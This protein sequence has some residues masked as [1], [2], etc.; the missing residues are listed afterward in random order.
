[1]GGGTAINKII[2]NYSYTGG[3]S[4]HV[5]TTPVIDALLIIDS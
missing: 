5:V 2:T 3:I 1:V 4:S